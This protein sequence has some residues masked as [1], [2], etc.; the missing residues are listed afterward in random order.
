MLIV[1]YNFM[2]WG[3]RARDY[4]I[5]VQKDMIKSNE[6]DTSLLDLRATLNQLNSRLE[7]VRKSYHL[8]K[9]WVAIEL[10]NIE[11][12]GREYRNGKVQYLDM[13]AGLNALS[14]AQNKFYS[15][16]AELH[17]VQFNILYHKGSLYDLLVK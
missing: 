16:S 6:I 5:S 4:E 9:E 15:V 7:N 3:T 17:N 2:D 11:Y 1:K 8:A 10:T 12:I 13:I 14:D